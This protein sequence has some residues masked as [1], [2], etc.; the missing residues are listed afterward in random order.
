[1]RT[2][3]GEIGL[4]P[5]HAPLL[6][7]L[8]DGP[9]VIR[10]IEGTEIKAAAHGGFVIVDSNNVIVLAETAELASEVDVKRA[11]KAKDEA[12]KSGDKEAL[13]RAESRLSIA[14]G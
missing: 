2:K 13:K 6:A 5:G 12:T 3:S 10:P 14:V 7:S 9:I 1:L 4:L 8:S 11:Q